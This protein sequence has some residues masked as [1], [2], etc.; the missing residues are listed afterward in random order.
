MQIF[1]VACVRAPRDSYV[2]AKICRPLELVSVR[3][4][5]SSARVVRIAN[6]YEALVVVM[7]VL[8]SMDF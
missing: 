7:Y 8:E 3:D 2:S 6:T 5:R 4:T 1:A